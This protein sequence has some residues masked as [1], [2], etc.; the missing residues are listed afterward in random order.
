[1]GDAHELGFRKGVRTNGCMSMFQ[2]W[3]GY[4]HHSIIKTIFLEEA[5]LSLLTSELWRLS[6][7]CSFPM[8]VFFSVD[9]HVCTYRHLEGSKAACQKNKK[10]PESF[11]HLKKP[12]ECLEKINLYL[13]NKC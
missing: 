10:K 2:G 3:T 6:I 1:V 7:C 12:S 9:V 5:G 13:E 8:T 11:S 4:H